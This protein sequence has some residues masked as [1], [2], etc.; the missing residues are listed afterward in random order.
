MT[1]HIVIFLATFAVGSVIA[2]VARTG[3]HHP[4]AV[5]DQAGAPPEPMAM[6][7]PVTPPAPTRDPAAA[8][9]PAAPAASAPVRAPEAKPATEHAG[10]D[11]HG[12]GPAP[13]PVQDT[14][15]TICPGCGDP[16]NPVIPYADYK[17][18]K[19]GFGCAMC[20][21]KFKADPVKYGEA[22]LRNQEAE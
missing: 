5:H 17:G 3:S 16:V 22:A 4:Y 2:V 7:A 19:V 14:V 9:P 6:P 15:N 1:R 11:H 20:P 18:K 10:H 8:A 21:P 13:A 12:D